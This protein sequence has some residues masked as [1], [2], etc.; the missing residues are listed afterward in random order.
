MK[1]K[2]LI[3]AV[4]SLAM[5]I[6]G[7]FAVSATQVDFGGN[8]SGGSQGSTYIAARI[9]TTTSG[10]YYAAAGFDTTDISAPHT[11]T[12]NTHLRIYQSPM[13]SMTVDKL[14]YGYDSGAFLGKDI[15]KGG[16]ETNY[17]P[18]HYN[19]NTYVYSYVTMDV[20]VSSSLYGSWSGSGRMN[21]T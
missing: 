17:P 1:A 6:G 16:V 11:L 5:V 9:G 7:S 21:Y 4:L 15:E 19:N 8:T 20:A 10:A 12:I 18:N 14:S 2:K 13:G 3:A